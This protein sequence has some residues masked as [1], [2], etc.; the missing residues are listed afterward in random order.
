VTATPRVRVFG[1][2]FF[3]N[4]FGGTR[5]NGSHD[6]RFSDPLSGSL[7][8]SINL[9]NF[10]DPAVGSV[11]QPEHIPTE[12]RGAKSTYWL[13]A[14]RGVVTA[15][16]SA[17]REHLPPPRV[18]VTVLWGVGG[19][20]EAH[21]L[22][23]VFEH[24]NTVLIN[25]SGREGWSDLPDGRPAGRT[26]PK[27]GIGISGRVHLPAGVTDN[28]VVAVLAAAGL[29]YVEPVV[30]TL[31]AYSTGYRGLLQS[32]NNDLLPLQDLRRIIF[33]DCLYRADGPPRP[34]SSGAPR[35]LPEEL[36]TGPDELVAGHQNS[37]FNTRR[38][39]SKALSAQPRTEVVAYSVTSGGS[40]FYC[41]ATTAD[42]LQHLVAVPTLIELRAV[43]GP[44]G[45]SPGRS[46]CF[47]N[48]RVP[49]P[50][51]ARQL[52]VN[53]GLTALLLARYLQTGVKDGFFSSTTVP[54]AFGRLAARLPA[55]GQIASSDRTGKSH[56]VMTLEGWQSANA[57]LIADALT[58]QAQ[59]KELIGLH[60]LIL[61][62]GAGLG[63][64][65]HRGFV[66][67]FGWEYLL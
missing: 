33:F 48:L 19:E 47:G 11:P 14:P 41:T 4:E 64:E 27:W 42:P 55:R 56:R 26:F 40:P 54:A 23:A 37:A 67:E 17:E 3:E 53:N 51:R 34:S 28:Q 25:V 35:L 49:A 30:T 38:A 6:N 16:R 13:F 2:A 45:G 60:N 9:P 36:N 10:L 65:L 1:E 52:A 44:S 22:R 7:L 12:W 5:T 63:E 18:N 61:P 50:R 20:I 24:A 39:L 8:K 66:S 31:A 46:A 58:R 29:R 59:A 32:L 43:P 57:S 21:G 62:G 15:I